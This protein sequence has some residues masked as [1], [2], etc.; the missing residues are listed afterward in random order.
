MNPVSME[1]RAHWIDLDNDSSNFLRVVSRFLN[2]LLLEDGRRSVSQLDDQH[3]SLDFCPSDDII[4][5]NL[6]SHM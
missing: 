6:I 2:K 3:Y 1:I 4:R 5:V